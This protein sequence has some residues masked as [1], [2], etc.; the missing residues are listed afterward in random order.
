MTVPPRLSGAVDTALAAMAQ[1][2]DHWDG[3]ARLAIA[4]TARAAFAGRNDPP[5]MRSEPTSDSAAID[6]D[7]AQ[8]VRTLA[9]DLHL[10]DREWAATATARLGEAAYVEVVAIVASLAI[11]DAFAEALGEAAPDL[12]GESQ[13]GDPRCST[14]SDLPYEVG[15]IGAYVSMRTPWS[16]ANVGRA[17]T[18]SVAGNAMYQPLAGAMYHDGDFND[19]SWNRTLSRPAT[20]L[21]ATAVSAAHE[22]FY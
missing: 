13:P 10:V 6:A 5:W 18:L 21:L 8:I 3:A 2:G 7:V 19:L 15:D 16:H 1:P 4:A 9:A 22:C 12:P 14:A 11:V 17:L 20:E